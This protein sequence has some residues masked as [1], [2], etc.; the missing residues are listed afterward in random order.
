MNEAPAAAEIVE[1]GDGFVAVKG[2]FYR[3]DI[4][5][6]MTQI[7]FPA[8]DRLLLDPGNKSR[9]DMVV[10]VAPAMPQ[11]EPTYAGSPS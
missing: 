10:G 1:S 3:I 7:A 5:P 6:K 9:G 8:V 11:T 2:R 4:Q